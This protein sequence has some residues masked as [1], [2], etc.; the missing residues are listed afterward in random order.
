MTVR[1]LTCQ[2]CSEKWTLHDSATARFECS[3][4]RVLLEPATF[5]LAVSPAVMTP[6]AF[7]AL[8]RE[9]RELGASEVDAGGFR[10]KFGPLPRAMTTPTVRPV[11]AGFATEEQTAEWRER[12]KRGH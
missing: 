2:S 5:P 6:E 8:C 12:A 11:P 10:A 1:T 4:G 7:A 3:C 9:L